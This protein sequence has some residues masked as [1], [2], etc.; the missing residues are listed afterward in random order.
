MTTRMTTAE[1]QTFLAEPHVGVLSLARANAGPLTVPVWYD[2]RPGGTLWFLT[3]RNS[4]KGQLIELGTRLSLCAQTETA[5]YH[6]VSVE[7][8]V[9][10]MDELGDELLAM[11]TRYLGEAGGRAYAESSSEEDTVVVRVEPQSW[12]AVDY[13]KS[14]PAAG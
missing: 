14:H 12:L 8:P 6:Y 11:A 5:P 7:G 13:R 2:Y 4:L 1:K 3:G 9:T 10:A